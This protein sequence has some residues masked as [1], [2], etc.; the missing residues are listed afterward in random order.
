MNARTSASVATESTKLKTAASSVVVVYMMETG[1][2]EPCRGK[3]LAVE[4][5]VPIGLGEPWAEAGAGEDRSVA[6][7]Q[8]S[9]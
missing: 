9:G 4:K 3:R 7:V 1:Q 5:E 8:G 6:D 2:D